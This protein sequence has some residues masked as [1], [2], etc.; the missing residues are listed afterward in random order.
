MHI[1]HSKSLKTFLNK[2][3]N[4]QSETL[5]IFAHNVHDALHICNT[6]TAFLFDIFVHLGLPLNFQVCN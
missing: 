5:D 6:V 2:H 4:L 3:L 1:E